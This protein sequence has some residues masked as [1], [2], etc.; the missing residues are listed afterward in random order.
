MT[1]TE[2]LPEDR[3]AVLSVLTSYPPGIYF[4]QFREL[5]ATKHLNTTQLGLI[6][7]DARTEGLVMTDADMYGT[8]P[9][10][11]YLLTK[12]FAQQVELR[13][14]YLLDFLRK[15][16]DRIADSEYGVSEPN[17]PGTISAS[18]ARDSLLRSGFR[19]KKY[20][21]HKF[22]EAEREL[23]ILKD[24]ITNVTVINSRDREAGHFDRFSLEAT[25]LRFPGKPPRIPPEARRPYTMELMSGM[26]G[27]FRKT[28]MLGGFATNLVFSA[29]GQIARINEYVD[30]LVGFYHKD[31]P[32][33]QVRIVGPMILYFF[34]VETPSKSLRK[35]KSVLMKRQHEAHIDY[36]N[37]RIREILD[38]NLSYISPS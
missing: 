5:S 18:L 15:S 12:S 31:I 6:L 10:I 22:L 36:L 13:E 3:S 9:R 20:E 27:I 29:E 30:T 21:N 14:R 16:V 1:R 23:K 28:Q 35:G 26:R 11:K 7:R 38:L 8:E 34:E 33:D 19:E 2:Y 17:H 24:V 32:V 4:S 25:F 37:H